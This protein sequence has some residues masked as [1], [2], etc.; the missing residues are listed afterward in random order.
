MPRTLFVIHDTVR[1]STLQEIDTIIGKV[2]SHATT[3][4]AFSR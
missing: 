4:A 1:H 2:R 3:V